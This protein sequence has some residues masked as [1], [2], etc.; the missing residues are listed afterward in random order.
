MIRIHKEHDVLKTG[1][2]VYLKG[3]YQWIAYG[4][5]NRNDQM[6]VVLNNAEEA[7]DL[8]VP[9]WNLGIS[10]DCE[11]ANV[12]MTHADGYHMDEQVWPVERG[13]V[14]ITMPAYSAVVLKARNKMKG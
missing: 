14:N 5:F 12:I 4:R 11:L 13:C 2:Y 3:G 8:T 1:S 6:V 9:V 10:G 7:Q